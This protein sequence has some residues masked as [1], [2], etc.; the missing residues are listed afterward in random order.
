MEKLRAERAGCVA[1]SKLGF[2][3]LGV[4]WMVGGPFLLIIGTTC[5]GTTVDM[6]IGAEPYNPSIFG[7]WLIA[8]GLTGAL[9]FVTRRI[10]GQSRAVKRFLG[11][12]A[13]Q[14]QGRV[15][16][17]VGDTVYWLN[18]YWVD[19]V[20]PMKLFPGRY[21]GAAEMTV[22]GYPVLVDVN[23]AAASDQHQTYCSIRVACHIPSLDTTD[24]AGLYDEQADAI[25]SRLTSAGFIVSVSSAGILVE[26]GNSLLHTLKKAENILTLAKPVIEA[27]R[28]AIALDAVPGEEIPYLP[29]A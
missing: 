1:A 23:T 2:K 26:A 15:L 25:R 28:L 8:L 24:D 11:E 29:F 4:V 13:S 12:L 21:Y 14:W 6:M 17:G 3:A 20:D 9:L 27:T 7:Q 19:T 16:L 22:D 18:H 10:R 5:I